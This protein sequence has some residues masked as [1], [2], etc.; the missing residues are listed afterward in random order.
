MVSIPSLWLAI[1]LSSVLVF[2]GSSV[3]HMVLTYHKHDFGQVPDEDAVMG[4]LRPFRIPPGDYV[5][6]YAGS[7]EVMKSPE[8]KQKTEDGPVAFMTILAPGAFSN[9]GAQLAQWFVYCVVVSVVTAYVATRTMA[10]GADYLAVFRLVGTVAF[11]CYAMSL[12]QR[13]IWYKQSWGATARSMF[14]GF[15]Y[16]CLTAGA[17][18]WLWP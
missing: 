9:M 13:A 10:A 14:D 15:V 11:A 5:M 7:S 18:G 3:L 12:P 1:I 4:A 6:P 8:Y 2:I 16:A 17:F